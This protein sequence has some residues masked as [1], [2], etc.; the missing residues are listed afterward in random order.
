[1]L[2]TKVKTLDRYNH[3]WNSRDAAFVTELFSEDATFL[4][5]FLDAPLRGKQAIRNHLTRF[6]AAFPDYRVDDAGT[7]VVRADHEAVFLQRAAGTLTGILQRP[8]GPIQPPTNK[9][10]AADLAVH[11]VLNRDGLIQAL[12]AY[13]DAG[14][15]RRQLGIA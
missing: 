13:G 8:N 11:V 2:G 14:G 5:P 7:R 4:D 6:F 1:M 9:P 10:F 3:Y 12:R 15:V